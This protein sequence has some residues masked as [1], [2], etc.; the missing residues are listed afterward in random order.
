VKYLDEVVEGI[1]DYYKIDL[2]AE[3]G[4]SVRNYVEEN[5]ENLV[6]NSPSQGIF[7]LLKQAGVIIGM[8]GL[9][10]VRENIGEIKRMYIREEYRGKGY[11]RALLD[12][13]I[14]KAKDFGYHK[15]FLDTG[16]FLIPAIHLYKSFGFVRREEYPETEVPKQI[17]SKWIYMEKTL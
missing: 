10:K 6:P 2:S 14:K 12:K 17:R 3:M 13:L 16:P 4:I 9:R 15:I 1:N 5:I 8:G 7:Y 11:G